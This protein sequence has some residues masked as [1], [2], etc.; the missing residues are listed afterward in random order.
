MKMNESRKQFWQK[1]IG[2]ALIWPLPA[3]AAWGAHL[4][5]FPKAHMSDAGPGF[6]I[7]LMNQKT[8]KA[9][10]AWHFVDSLFHPF[11]LYGLFLFAIYLLFRGRRIC[12]S[13]RIIGFVILALPG[14]WYFSIASCLGGKI[15]AL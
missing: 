10:H 7:A 9:Q 4:Y 3:I 15:M 11:L 2:E 5:A 6:Y 8:I 12:L 13:Y 14:F 1:P